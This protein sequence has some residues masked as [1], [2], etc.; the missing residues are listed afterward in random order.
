MP[1]LA[2]VVFALL[3]FSADTPPPSDPVAALETALSDAIAAAEPSVVAIARD[4]G[5]KGEPTVAIRGRFPAR[6]RA[7]D[8][9]EIPDYIA[10]DYASGVVIGDRNQILTTA[11]AVKGATR[12][13]VR[14]MGHPD[15]DAEIIASDPRSDLAVI[16]P[17]VGPD[18]PPLKLKPIAI[19]PPSKIRKG[20]FLLALGNAFNTARDGQA[21][22][23]W[24]IL[25]NTARRMNPA[26]PEIPNEQQL[27]HFPSLY[28]LDAKLNLGMSGGA[29]INLKGELIGLTTNAVNAGGFDVQAGYAIPM[30]AI[31]RR[32]IESLREGKEVEYGML[33]IGLDNENRTSRIKNVQAG[34]PAGEGGLIVD[35]QILSIGGLPVTDADSLVTT[36][37]NFPPGTPIKLRISRE[38]QEMEKT[39]VLSK[40]PVFGEVIATNRSALW[41]GLR[42]DF[43]SVMAG[44]LRADGVLEAMARGGVRIVE[45]QAGSPADEAGLKPGQIIVG[46]EDRRVTNPSEFAQAVA[47]LPGPVTLTLEANQTVSVPAR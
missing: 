32:A 30:D 47:S 22:A 19:A 13:V 38:G 43:V 14:S 17:R 46:V 40:L 35:D 37:N 21:S 18:Q 31:A 3:A 28:Q 34:T 45:V 8:L 29:V 44:G 39:V 6:P 4:I 7:I 27:R 11:H 15:F 41:R 5:K 1:H 9:D 26:Q 42:V 36:V 23:S 33:G 20:S 25:A 24:G 12:L 10:S 2:P 16:A